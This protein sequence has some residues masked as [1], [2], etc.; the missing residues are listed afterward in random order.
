MPAAIRPP[1]ARNPRF[2]FDHLARDLAGFNILSTLTVPANE[3]RLRDGAGEK[4]VEFAAPLNTFKQMELDRTAAGLRQPVNRVIIPPGHNSGSVGWCL[5]VYDNV[6]TNTFV[7]RV[8]FPDGTAFILPLAG[9]MP[10][11]VPIDLEFGQGLITS[12]VKDGASDRF[13][14]LLTSGTPG[15]TS[16]VVLGELWVGRQLQASSGVAKAWRVLPKRG[17]VQVQR[18]QGGQKYTTVLGDEERSW[19]LRH[20][21]CSDTD[22][23]TVYEPLLDAYHSGRAFWWDPPESGDARYI[24]FKMSDAAQWDLVGAA[25]S[26]ISVANVGRDSY[27]ADDDTDSAIQFQ[28]DGTAAPAQGV[29]TI[30][31]ASAYHFPNGPE[32]WRNYDLSVDINAPVDAP[33]WCINPDDLRVIVY[34]DDVSSQWSAWALAAPW[35]ANNGPPPAASFLFRLW[36]DLANKAPV[37][38][39]A[40]GPANLRAVS[41]WGLVIDPTA[42]QAWNFRIVRVTLHDR[43]KVPRL[44]I[45]D[46]PPRFTQDSPA[47]MTEVTWNVEATLTEVLA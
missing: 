47:P 9:G 39:G 35:L 37:A 3:P 8:K 38:T 36:T 26:K 20:N 19:A 28:T 30:A 16:A 5:D 14:Q 41:G 23:R 31:G 6:A 1:G 46:G 44:V 40:A 7:T 25:A 24:R 11:G 4:T 22:K 21:R 43:T 42:A 15:P 13:M 45:C 17:T 2:V 27:H 33:A 12:P 32:D 10:D 18:M 29:R 34:S